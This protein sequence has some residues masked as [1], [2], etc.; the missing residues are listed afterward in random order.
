MTSGSRAATQEWGESAGLFTTGLGWPYPLAG[1]RTYVPIGI[2]ELRDKVKP[3][4]RAARTLCVDY[5]HGGHLS[6]A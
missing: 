3:E 2:S 6:D 5:Q 1:L 4:F